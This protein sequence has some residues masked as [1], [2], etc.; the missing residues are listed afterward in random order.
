MTTEKYIEA[1][2]ANASKA[3]FKAVLAK[4]PNVAADFRDVI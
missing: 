4:V 1:R 3:K 2:A